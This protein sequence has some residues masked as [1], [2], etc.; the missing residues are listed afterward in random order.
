M[1]LKVFAAVVS[2]I[3]FYFILSILDWAKEMLIYNSLPT[4]SLEAFFIVYV[5]SLPAFL[6]IALP[7]SIILDRIPYGLRWVNY[8]LSGL[9]GGVIVV[10]F[11][12]LR[13]VENL[14]ISLEWVVGYMIAGGAFYCSLRLLETFDERLQGNDV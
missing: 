13:G 7:I 9:V 3:V 11:N 8:M 1:M 2:P 14:D 12:V 4:L 10:V 6:L 5:F